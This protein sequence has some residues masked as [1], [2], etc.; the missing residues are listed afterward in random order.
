[1][2]TLEFQHLS[3]GK[4][5]PA[6][7]RVAEQVL[8]THHNAYS[9]L[10]CR[11]VPAAPS[12]PVVAQLLQHLARVGLSWREASRRAGFGDDFVSEMAGNN[13]DRRPRNSRI[14]TLERLAYVT[15]AK[16][17]VVQTG[18]PAEGI[19]RGRHGLRPSPAPT[20]SYT[21][22]TLRAICARNG[23][24]QLKV[25]AVAGYPEGFMGGWFKNLPRVC[26]VADVAQT[27]GYSLAVVSDLTDDIG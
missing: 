22:D 9:V 11:D 18:A 1:M 23:W 6:G 8:G 20:G 19:A 13:V 16:L 27:M 17:V 25:S 3:H 24:S 4:P 12:R 21:A 2:H 15:G 14:D 7:W 10:I 5:I 26:G